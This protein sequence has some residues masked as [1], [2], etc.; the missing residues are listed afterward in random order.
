MH[1]YVHYHIIHNRQYMETTDVSNDDGWIRCV[2][3]HRHT[4]NGILLSY[5][6]KNEILVYRT[7]MDL[8]IL[9]EISKKKERQIMYDFTYIWNLKN[10]TNEQ[11]K[12]KLIDAENSDG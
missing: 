1:P 11:T 2:Y 4:H 3:V 9:G 12:Q 6:Q 5:Y 8:E 7:S 10:R